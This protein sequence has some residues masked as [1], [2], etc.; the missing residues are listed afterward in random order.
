MLFWIVSFVLCS[1]AFIILCS[2][3][4][5][6]TCY[7]IWQQK[8]QYRNASCKA[9]K[10]ALKILYLIKEVLCNEAIFVSFIFY[11]CISNRI[12]VSIRPLVTPINFI[13]NRFTEHWCIRSSSFLSG[14]AF[15]HCENYASHKLLQFNYRS[16]FI[17][18]AYMFCVVASKTT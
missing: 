12:S 11:S 17:I 18:R 15:T 8:K 13:F 9:I 1:F 5:P 16:T 14:Q 4:W 6:C 7:C 3:V 2:S 10:Q